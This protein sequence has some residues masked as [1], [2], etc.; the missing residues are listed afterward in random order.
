MTVDGVL[1]RGNLGYHPRL[2]MSLHS[3]SFSHAD[4]PRGRG[5]NRRDNG[6]LLNGDS[7]SAGRGQRHDQ[8]P[9]NPSGYRVHSRDESPESHPA[10]VSTKSSRQSGQ[11]RGRDNKQLARSHR[12]EY[13]AKSSAYTAHTS[14][15]RAL[16]RISH[17]G[18]GSQD[19]GRILRGGGITKFV[20]DS[21]ASCDATKLR[22]VRRD[23]QASRTHPGASNTTTNLSGTTRL[24]AR[25]REIQR[26]P[27][28][29]RY[30]L[31]HGKPVVPGSEADDE[32]DESEGGAMAHARCSCLLHLSTLDLWVS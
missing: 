4:P 16:T 23:A 17:K 5:G 24:L 10:V 25:K 22:P 26:P 27:V 1:W 15:S 8:D 29:H 6:R 31:L 28:S 9:L 13:P 19:G 12:R 2:H 20:P 14:Q 11:K 3:K 21:S 7:R 32:D 18:H 30:T